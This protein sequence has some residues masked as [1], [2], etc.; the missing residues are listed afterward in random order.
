VLAA[1]LLFG[2]RARRRAAAAKAGAEDR[3]RVQRRLDG[4]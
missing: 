2:R 1:A 4:M 3:G